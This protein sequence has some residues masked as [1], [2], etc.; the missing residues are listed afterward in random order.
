MSSSLLT[1]RRLPP[2]RLL[3]SH[4]PTCPPHLY[5]QLRSIAT[6]PSDPHRPIRASPDFL[7]SLNDPAL[8]KLKPAPAPLQA[9]REYPDDWKTYK[10]PL[11]AVKR[12]V[13]WCGIPMYKIPKENY[14]S[15]YIK[16]YISLVISA[17]LAFSYGFQTWEKLAGMEP[18][19]TDQVYTTK[20]R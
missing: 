9:E 4:P 14:R 3:L 1:L 5:L 7:S 6:P 19:H 20:V 10:L 2:S 12:V 8:R 15:W 13:W 18:E 11:R 17:C 16:V